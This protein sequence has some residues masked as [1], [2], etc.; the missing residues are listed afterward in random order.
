MLKKYKILKS[1]IS[2]VLCS[3]IVVT[4]MFDY[5]T[6]A[7][8]SELTS[9]NSAISDENILADTKKS[10]E[11]SLVSN[12]DENKDNDVKI[13]TEAV[14]DK[15]TTTA[16]TKKSTTAENINQETTD[17]A[18]KEMSVQGTAKD[19]VLEVTKSTETSFNEDIT[20][21]QEA[22]SDSEQT[23]T[24]V[25]KGVKNENFTS[26]AEALNRIDEYIRIEFENGNTNNS[27][28]NTYTIRFNVPTYELT[29]D[30][31]E[32]IETARKATIVY[33]GLYKEENEDKYYTAL[34]LNILGDEGIFFAND[35]AI[36]NIKLIYDKN[37]A[38]NIDSDS[39]AAKG[40]G[41]ADT[42]S[43]STV[44][45][46][47]TS[48][49]N[50]VINSS[51]VTG[52]KYLVLAANGYKLTIGQNVE[53]PDNTKVYSGFAGL[54]GKDLEESDKASLGTQS[55]L[56]INSGT[57]ESVIAGGSKEQESSKI[58]IQGGTINNIYGS[59]SA[60]LN[61]TSILVRGGVYRR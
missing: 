24:L 15:N 29:A 9:V 7:N 46:G 31:V 18:S 39:A 54:K 4:T 57:Y 38:E 35:T 59:E 25:I 50:G 51:S 20:K 56:I 61:M 40:D 36:Q 12:S 23:V 45:N 60:N 19:G 2:I 16:T 47:N 52:T 55:E 41:S 42:E 5:T 8:A 10:D 1:I 49:N 26:I 21:S 6:S 33:D 11:K 14:A 28:A 44:K 32:A 48:K 58:I 37:N 30:D 17:Y 53:T 13:T 43:N 22:Q 3:I 27:A 34:D